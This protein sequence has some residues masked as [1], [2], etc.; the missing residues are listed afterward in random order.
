MRSSGGLETEALMS[1][2]VAS[3]ES[4]RSC[5]LE[6]RWY[7]D[8]SSSSSACES[9]FVSGGVAAREPSSSKR[10]GAGVL[11]LALTASS[12]DAARDNASFSTAAVAG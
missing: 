8:S 9:P 1:F 6:G 12:A 5:K 10:S 7:T 2:F 4:S 11:L 3:K